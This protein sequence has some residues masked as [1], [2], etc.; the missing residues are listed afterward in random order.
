M[1]QRKI[2]NNSIIY[3]IILLANIFITLLFGVGVEDS[4][5]GYSNSEPLYGED[6][7]IF[8]MATIVFFSSI[9][10]LFS[11]IFKL[12]KTILFLNIMLGLIVLFFISG[13]FRM[14]FEGGFEI[15]DL[16]KITII[17]AL[18]FLLFVMI[19]LFKIKPEQYENIDEIGKPENN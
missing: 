16:I 11:L 15:S 1:K 9:L 8:I 10:A 7:A 2:F 18:I 5:K 17:I 6:N 19:Q 14:F 12:K 3:Y 4:F 13:F